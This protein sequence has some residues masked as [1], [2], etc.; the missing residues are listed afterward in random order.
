MGAWANVASQSKP[1]GQQRRI[2]WIIS[3]QLLFI[4]V[5]YQ[6][7]ITRMILYPFEIIGTVFHEFGHAITVS[8]GLPCW[9][10]RLWCSAG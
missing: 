7:R 9:L 3:A 5:M 6:W 4:T 8:P 1:D 2:L 10:C